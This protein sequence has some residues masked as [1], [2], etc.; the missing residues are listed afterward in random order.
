MF[1]DDERH[2]LFVYVYHPYLTCHSL[3]DAAESV[4][5]HERYAFSVGS[6]L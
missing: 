6:L 4:E 2:V 3:D 5:E 1:V